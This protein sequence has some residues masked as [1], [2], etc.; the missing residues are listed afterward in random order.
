MTRRTQTTIGMPAI[1]LRPRRPLPRKPKRGFTLIEVV[2]AFSILALGLALSMQIATTAMRQTRQAS[3]H[4]I[5]ALHAQSLL[6]TTGVGERIEIGETDGEFD[7]G[8]RWHLIVAPYELGAEG[9]PEGLDPTTAP[10]QLLELTL[11]ISWERGG[12]TARS[13]FRTL[14]AMLPDRLQ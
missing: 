9:L 7:D 12:Q 3:E 13:E 1:G 4:T 10:V 2:A 5:A 11:T 14:R 6:D 8:Y